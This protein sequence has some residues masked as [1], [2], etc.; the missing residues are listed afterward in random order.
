MHCEYCQPALKYIVTK[1]FKRREELYKTKEV[2]HDATACVWKRRHR[3]LV[4]QLEHRRASR[5]NFEEY[6]TDDSLVHKSCFVNLIRTS[7]AYTV[8]SPRVIICRELFEHI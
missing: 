8:Y 2:L 4:Q 7:H 6:S 1:P 3:G 5:P